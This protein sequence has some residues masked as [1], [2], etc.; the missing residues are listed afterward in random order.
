[1]WVFFY[2]LP[3]TTRHALWKKY[4]AK[5]AFRFEDVPDKETRALQREQREKLFREMIKVM[6]YLYHCLGA[7]ESIEEI[8]IDIDIRAAAGRIPEDLRDVCHEAL[9][10]IRSAREEGADRNEVLTHVRESA[11]ALCEVTEMVG[12]RKRPHFL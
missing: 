8:K 4:G 3:T 1:M 2:D 11:K 6:E 9:E 10:I 5:I 12:L 7:G